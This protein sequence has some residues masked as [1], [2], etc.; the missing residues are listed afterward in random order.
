MY[1]EIVRLLEN[2]TSISQF[3]A[4]KLAN[5]KLRQCL[6][7]GEGTGAAR[8]VHEW[9]RAKSA[10]IS[11]KHLESPARIAKRATENPELRGDAL[12]YNEIFYEKDERR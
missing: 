9:A 10:A 1:L 3:A 6:V 7:E 2:L 8:F 11:H 4:D 5:I 12:C